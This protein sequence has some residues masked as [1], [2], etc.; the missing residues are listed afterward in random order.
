MMADD[1]AKS[2]LS[3]YLEIPP[4]PSKLPSLSRIGESVT[5][6]RKCLKI[7]DLAF[8]DHVHRLFH[9]HHLSYF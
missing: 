6:S 2:N 5:V 8:Y 3:D 9:D 4:I 7:S 1:F